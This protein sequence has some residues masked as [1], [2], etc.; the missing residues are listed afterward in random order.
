MKPTMQKA[1]R[2]RPEAM[3]RMYTPERAAAA[4]TPWRSLPRRVRG[5]PPG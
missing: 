5:T 1:V 4:T 3:Q 2:A